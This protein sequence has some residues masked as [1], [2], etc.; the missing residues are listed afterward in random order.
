M[1]G[2]F[3]SA[4]SLAYSVNRGQNKV[5]SM[6]IFFNNK[7]D[8]QS[9]QGLK[10]RELVSKY[11]SDLHEGLLVSEKYCVSSIGVRSHMASFPL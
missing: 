4:Q 5:N 11:S 3:G 1:W 10:D 6:I 2:C 8:K 9:H 7:T